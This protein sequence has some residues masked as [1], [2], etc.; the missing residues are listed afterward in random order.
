M[1]ANLEIVPIGTG[2][3]YARPGEVQSCH[4]V[5]AGGRAIC[6]D[7]GSGALNRL[8]EHVAPHALE[9]LVVTHLHP[10]HLVDLLAL[11]VYMAW[12]PGR[13]HRLPVLG[14]P[15]LRALVDAHGASGT[16]A[17]FAFESF[18]PGAGERDLGG[19]LVLRH[20]EVPHLPPTNAVRLD[21]G[22]SSVC[23]GADC[24]PN[25]DLVDLARGVDVLLC[26][27]SFGADA[28]PE[29]VPHLNATMA[30]DIARRAG[31]GRL[32]LTHCYPE[33]DRD[34]ALAAAR[35]AF[36]GPAEWARS[37]VAVAA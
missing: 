25:D 28:V 18:A 23:F 22:G 3:A 36:G 19:G 12:G 37:G 31:V 16:D 13:G 11:R 9:R 6:L 32:V 34:A 21:L 10:D 27:C 30:G 17:A 4:L 33:H 35:D 1:S 26:E 29:D 24:G 8:Q 14:P 2:A 15:G 7:L 20:R 5:R